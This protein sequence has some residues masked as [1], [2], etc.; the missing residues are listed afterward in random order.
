MTSFKGALKASF[1]AMN[2]SPKNVYVPMSVKLEMR[3]AAAVYG[4]EVMMI[5]I[6]FRKCN[7][8]GKSRRID[9]GINWVGVAAANN[10]NCFCA[11]HYR[12]TDGG[13]NQKCMR[14]NQ[15]GN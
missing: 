12:I 5:M 1:I 2:C 9:H 7:L 15:V 10:R 14:I 13:D 3:L 8:S 11:N 4:L 6:E